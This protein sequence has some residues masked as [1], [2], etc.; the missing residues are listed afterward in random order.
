MFSCRSSEEGFVCLKKSEIWNFPGWSR[1]G[2]RKMGFPRCL[3]K[4]FYVRHHSKPFYRGMPKSERRTAPDGDAREPERRRLGR[5]G[6]FP[7]GLL[8]RSSRAS[9]VRVSMMKGRQSEFC[10]VCGGV[11]ESGGVGRPWLPRLRGPRSS[12]P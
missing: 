9:T 12:R 2:T 8:S 5:R 3:L 4:G 10:G 6:P 11:T 1:V 7:E